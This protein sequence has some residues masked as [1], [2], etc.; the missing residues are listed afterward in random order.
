MKFFKFLFF[1][2]FCFINPTCIASDNIQFDFNLKDSNNS[3]KSSLYLFCS[4]KNSNLNTKIETP[5]YSIFKL[6]LY[7]MYI[8]NNN[9]NLRTQQIKLFIEKY[10]NQYKFMAESMHLKM[11]LKNSK[12]N[13][14]FFKL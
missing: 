14:Y 4:D 8:N 13:F 5:I 9:N 3:N 7:S 11:Y 1:I 12:K 2:N 10:D 6:L